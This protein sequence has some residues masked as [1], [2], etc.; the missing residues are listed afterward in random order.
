[1]SLVVTSRNQG[2][3]R[4]LVANKPDNLLPVLHWSGTRRG[5]I[6]VPISSFN[7]KPP[8]KL[9]AYSIPDAIH[10]LQT[11]YDES[12]Y[13]YPLAQEQGVIQMGQTYALRDS[14]APCTSCVLR[15]YFVFGGKRNPLGSI[16]IEDGGNVRIVGPAGRFLWLARKRKSKK[17]R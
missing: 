7:L 8:L 4:E 2:A 1:M 9:V 5:G 15:V 14:R 10:D 17:K 3:F 12:S 13:F 16:A 6:S 11:Y